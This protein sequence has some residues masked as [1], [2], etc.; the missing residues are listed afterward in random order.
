MAALLHLILSLFFDQFSFFI[1]RH[2]FDGA[3]P[4]HG[5]GSIGLGLV[6]D[7]CYRPSHT[8]IF[9]PPSG[10]MRL[11]ASFYI[12]C[13]TG[14]E[15]AIRTFNDIAKTRHAFLFLSG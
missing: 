5:A 13:P 3:L 14:I 8:G 12:G 9:C 7:K 10:I 11:D 1:A 6:V 4:F 15:T 2:R